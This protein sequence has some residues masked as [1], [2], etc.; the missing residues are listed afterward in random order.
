MNALVIEYYLE[1]LGP[2]HDENMT[3]TIDKFL[4]FLRHGIGKKNSAEPSK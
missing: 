1:H 2:E 4:D 3:E